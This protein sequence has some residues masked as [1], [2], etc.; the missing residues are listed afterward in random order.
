VA[1]L[2]ALAENPLVAEEASAAQRE[3]LLWLPP[4]AG[5]AR[6]LSAW[7]DRHPRDA[8]VAARLAACQ[9]STARSDAWS[10]LEQ[11]RLGLAERLFG[12]MDGSD[13]ERLAG[14]AMVALRRRD[15]VQAK[16]LAEQARTQAPNR[17][18][19]WGATL[20][21]AEFRVLLGEAERARTNGQLD[22]AEAKLKE[23][24]LAPVPQRHEADVALGWLLADRGD[25]P[26]A[27]ARFRQVLVD[28]PED[29]SAGRA[30]VELLLRTGR[31]GEAAGLN[32][33]L[34]R[35][36][37]GQAI[38]T[39][40]LVAAQRRQ[41]ADAARRSGDLPG[42]I[43]ELRLAHEADPGDVWV[44]FD[45]AN[46]ELEGGDAI[47]AAADTAALLRLHPELAVARVLEARVLAAQGRTAEA[48]EKLRASGLVAGDPA[49]A[50]FETR[51]TLER[52]ASAAV[53]VLSENPDDAR[54][55]L[56]ALEAR[57]GND[58]D[59][60]A[61]LAR[62]QRRAGA[63]ERAAGLLRRAIAVA[64]DGRALKM[65]LAGTLLQA[66]QTGEELS[67]LLTEVESDPNLRPAERK[68][69]AELRAG[70]A[71]QRA[72]ALR[73][74]GDLR[75]AVAE[76]APALARRPDDP[77][78]LA[79]LA[80]VLDAEDDAA[81]AR[82]VYL[83]LL[84]VRPRDLDAREGAVRASERLGDRVEARRL[85]EEGVALDPG[86][87]RAHL[88]QAR[89][90]RAEGDDGAALQALRNALALAR[91]PGE[92]DALSTGAQNRD[93]LER[94]ALGAQRPDA[95]DAPLEEGIAREI[96]ELE[97]ARRPAVGGGLEFRS[98]TGESG[99]SALTGLTQRTQASA[100][101]AGGR[102]ALE[103]EGVE[104]DAGGVAP[105][106]SLESRFGG[107]GGVTARPQAAGM[108]LAL[109]W[110]SRSLTLRAG[111]TPVGF[112]IWNALGAVRWSGSAGRFALALE[113]ARRP[114]TETL[115]SYAGTRD[116]MTGKAW[117]G[118]VRQGV[119]G[120][121][122]SSG[123]GPS[124]SVH[125]G[126]DV[127]TGTGV[128]TN[129]AISAGASSSWALSGVDQAGAR[130]GLS[131]ETAAYRLNLH[132]FTLGHGG[133]FSPQLFVHA[134]AP[135]SLRM[136]KPLRIEV[137]AE[138]GVN[139]QREASVSVAPLGAGGPYGAGVY[140]GRTQVGPAL[141]ARAGVTW[142]LGG[143]LEAHA[144]L[145]FHRSQDYQEVLAGI[146]IDYGSGRGAR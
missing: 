108:G 86:A 52:D 51:L 94:A 22:V 81:G 146:G 102:A 124:W 64:Q 100:A 135:L 128:A 49:L 13:P 116:P 41:R 143:A 46:A 141:D 125:A 54:A 62:A 90:V 20:R 14:L 88:I 112:P 101:L 71:V 114:V 82:S 27:E 23:A 65:E 26:G 121:M 72:D 126:A 103:V 97:A 120:E 68:A 33:Q 70:R 91:P 139:F 105:Q 48:L 61:V 104:L 74:K 115:L 21:Q 123:P 8:E 40:R 134:G 30:L 59:L 17:E 85:A 75:G 84:A 107:G 78:L 129:Q 106:A 10:A 25:L 15:P 3:A 42:A 57:A 18:D 38:P 24:A 133:Y 136:R 137:S 2:A 77:R 5:S 89:V 140:P 56:G 37:P 11:G 35:K 73:G 58:P 43:T 144:Q 53:A 55:R 131:V 109:T 119:R 39:G 6:L 117:G 9:A 80:R 111:S 67:A 132:Y 12:R 4:S 1:R 16:E 31:S 29:P 118:V 66:G 145:T 19:L 122:V 32:E 99:L 47:A 36:H 130:A 92:G 95:P 28:E 110:A 113:A 76:L 127:L 138:P 87:A 60:L 69:L 44:L 142:S 7:L 96:A 63:P 98:R 83:R 34:R 50:A 45:L 79:A 93:A